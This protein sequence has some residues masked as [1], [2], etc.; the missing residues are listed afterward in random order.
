[1]GTEEAHREQMEVIAVAF[2]DV[3][4]MAAGDGPDTGDMLNVRDNTASDA[5]DVGS[6]PRKSRA[7]CTDMIQKG[8]VGAAL[9]GL[10]KMK[11]ELPLPQQKFK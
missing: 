3:R 2:L 6:A 1:M 5:P 8:H 11:V 4:D 9:L 10:L 7:A